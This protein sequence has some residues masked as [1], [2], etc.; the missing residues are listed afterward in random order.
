[1]SHDARLLLKAKHENEEWING[2][3]TEEYVAF[4]DRLYTARRKVE[5]RI[6]VLGGED[7]SVS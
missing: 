1:M 6:A 4:L 2:R 7:N 3:K 5:K